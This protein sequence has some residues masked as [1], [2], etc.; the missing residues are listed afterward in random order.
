MARYEVNGDEACSLAI[1][2]YAHRLRHYIGA[3]MA[4]LGG[5]DVLAFTD[6]VGLQVWQMREMACAGMEWAGMRLDA[7]ANRAADPRQ[8]ATVHQRA[9]AV[10][11]LVVPND[12]ERVIAEEGIRLYG[13]R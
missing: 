2:V 13:T 1:A 6:D 8:L 10:Q 11:I 9:S 4:V 3:Y 5:L 12:E 7:A